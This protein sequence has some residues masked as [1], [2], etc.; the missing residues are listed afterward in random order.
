MIT[1]QICQTDVLAKFK[2]CTALTGRENLN[3]EILWLNSYPPK[4]KHTPPTHKKTPNWCRLHCLIN[5]KTWALS[6]FESSDQL[7]VWAK[8]R[9]LRKEKKSWSSGSLFNNANMPTS[10]ITSATQV[11]GGVEGCVNEYRFQWSKNYERQFNNSPFLHR[12]FWLAT[13]SAPQFAPSLPRHN[14][15]RHSDYS[16][17]AF[18]QKT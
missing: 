15:C 12:T 18:V 5:L 9:D 8:E 17:K 14:P 10:A 4:Y 13:F 6:T 3:K 1:T 16:C 2:C 11:L 7:T